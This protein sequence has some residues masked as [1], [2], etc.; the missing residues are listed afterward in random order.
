VSDR[1]LVLWRHGRTA[2]NLLGRAQGHAQVP[3]DDVGEGQAS[4]ASARLASYQPGFIWSSDLVRAVQTADA[5]ARLTGLEVRQDKRLREFDVGERQGMTM[6]EFARSRPDLYQQWAN[7][8]LSVEIPA[9]EPTDDVAARMREVLH[10][11]ADAVGPGQ[12]GVVV[13]HGASLRVGIATFFGLPPRHWTMFH[14]MSNCAW[15][16]LEDD[17]ERWGWRIVDY[18]AGTLPEPVMSD[19]MGR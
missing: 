4:V 9:A 12:T 15:A 11:A 17:G 8:D 6:L 13:G 3:L 19:D 5:L 14:G 2:W 18:N 1:R 10:E 16:V 7:G